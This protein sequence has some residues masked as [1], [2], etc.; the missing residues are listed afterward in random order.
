M[1][2]ITLRQFTRFFYILGLMGILAMLPFSKIVVSIG[3]F[4]LAGT[5]I[6]EKF[7]VVRWSA[8]F[9]Q[10]SMARKILLALP[11]T[12][13]EAGRG[14]VRGFGEF[15]RNRPALLFSSILL[16]H[17]IGLFFTIDFDYALK[18]LRTK[19]PLFLFPLFLSTSAPF[20]KKAFHRFMLFFIFSLL[21]ATVI[22][23]WKIN[24]LQFI[25]IRDVAR[26]VSH[27]IFALLLALGIFTLAFFILKRRTLPGWGRIIC[28]TLL[29][30]FG[31]YLFITK[32]MTGLLIIL[33]ILLMF[34]PLLIFRIRNWWYK[35]ALLLVIVA[36]GTIMTLSMRKV[37]WDYYHVK[38][39]YY[40]DLDQI[41]SRGNRYVHNVFNYQTENGNRTW[42]Y[43]QWDELRASWN[44][45]SRINFDSLDKKHQPIAFTI[46]RFLTSKGYRKDADAVERLTRE[47]VRAIENGDANYIFMKEFRVRGW[48][49]E[50]LAGY[51][52]YR[53]TGNPTG[54]SMMQRLEY[55][56]ASL[57][58]IERNW[59]TGVGTGDMNIAFEQEYLRMHTKLAPDQRWRSHNQFLSIF[60]GFGVFGLVWFLFAIFYP[61][62]ALKRF[63]DFFYLVFILIALLSMMTED[64][65]ESQMGVT[66]FAFFYSFF[67][68]ARRE[69]EPL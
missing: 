32:S 52:N 64:T 33:I 5:W 20:S 68:F 47:E 7:D 35:A 62:I 16:F 66:F 56:K 1:R 36:T 34:V 12:L 22:N 53:Q 21:V 2:S 29:V 38:P 19:L 46:V 24:H 57:G 65:I 54:S 18:D 69:K 17:L 63:D 6:V 44:L 49:Y 60:V 58:I 14:I 23:V 10:P 55:W 50:F 67:L 25:D 3:Q 41:T 59:L 15:L 37:V 27:I 30:W 8:F 11:Y 42:L 39:V 61:P 51:D 4:V 28:A 13:F 9:R 40:R 45:R 31:S 48:I 43:V 26:S